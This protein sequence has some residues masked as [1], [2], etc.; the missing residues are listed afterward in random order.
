MVFTE[1]LTRYLGGTADLLILLA[2]G[3]PESSLPPLDAVGPAEIRELTA[4]VPR[5]RERDTVLLAV[6]DLVGLRRAVSAVANYGTATTIGVWIERDPGTLP[7]PALRPEWPALSTAIASKTRRGSVL[8][9]T[10]SEKATVR[11][12]VGQ[13]AR[14]AAPSRSASMAWPAIGARRDEPEHWPVADPAATVAMPGRLFDPTVGSPPDLVVHEKGQAPATFSEHEHHVLARAPVVARAE[15]CLSWEDFERLTTAGAAEALER[16][17]PSSLGATDEKILN[18]I[19]FD[20]GP[21]GTPVRLEPG[22]Q[23]TLRMSRNGSEAIVVDATGR[24]SDADLP[25]LRSFPGVELGWRGGS[26]PQSYCRTVTD[27]ACAGVPLVTEEVPSWAATLLDPRLVEALG[28]PADLTDRLRREEHSVRLRRAALR[29]HASGPWR[30]GL[31]REHGLQITK[32]PTVSVLL[33]TRRR[34]MLPFALRQISRQRG[35]DMEVVV[36]THGFE[37]EAVILEGL[38]ESMSSSLTVLPVDASVLFG[39]A[40]NLAAERATGD[41]LLK[42]DDDDWYGPDFTADLL[43]A[44][45][46]S[47]AEIVGCAPEF[48]FIEPLWLMTR[49]PDD[50]EVYRPFVAGGTMLIDRGAFRALGGFR[51]TRKYV[52]ANLLSA[53]I[54][55]GGSVY[56]TH[57]LGYVLRRGGGGHTWDPGLGYFVKR[58]RAVEQWRGFTPS[59]LLEPDAVDVPTKGEGTHSP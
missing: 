51:S 17:G 24:I 36:A 49:R 47:G 40:M 41:V 6:R 38:R 7:M 44:R 59:K 25:R 21:T 43:L 16:R 27:L 34:E 28:A 33:V 10:F 5:P 29:H 13:I 55:A 1:P 22:Q 37:A 42:M 15:S 32:E 46:Y 54:N 52:D 14:A 57:G 8:L 11:S 4:P 31:A 45:G 30:R 2:P 12:V 20:R 50:S 26:G 19:L 35:A 39:D 3:T 23:K 56:R 48:T 53:T 18:P 9:L 58:N